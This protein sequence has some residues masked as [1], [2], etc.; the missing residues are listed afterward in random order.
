MIFFA[1]G[2]HFNFLSYYSS[3][4]H[5]DHYIWERSYI[6]THRTDLF[7]VW[8]WADTLDVWGRFSTPRCRRQRNTG[9]QNLPH[10]HRP[11][12]HFRLLT[13]CWC[14]LEAGKV[15][16][17]HQSV[18]F[19]CTYYLHST[20]KKS[21]IACKGPVKP[22]QKSG[23]TLR[24][25]FHFPPF[26]WFSTQEQSKQFLAKSSW[27]TP[28]NAIFFNKYWQKYELVCIFFNICGY[29]SKTWTKLKLKVQI[30]NF[31]I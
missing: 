9:C 29:F 10:Y 14:K 27:G 8:G 12:P 31:S 24:F 16:F 28:D 1:S 2:F 25:H 3:S 23:W 15:I 6:R 5:R 18:N 11:S 26:W 13:S 21:Y 20:Q 17:H 30:S 7:L 22:S 19:L 4:A